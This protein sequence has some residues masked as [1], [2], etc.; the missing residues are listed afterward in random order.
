MLAGFVV[1]VPFPV[2]VVCAVILGASS[3]VNGESEA[4]LR[5]RVSQV[6]LSTNP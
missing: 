4:G 6:L 1:T 2:R 3:H 5:A